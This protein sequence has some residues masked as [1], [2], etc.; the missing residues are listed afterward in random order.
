MLYSLKCTEMLIYLSLTL[1]YKGVLLTI[2]NNM[3]KVE[4]K[5]AYTLN[6]QFGL[7][8]YY[9]NKTWTRIFDS[10]RQALVFSDKFTVFTVTVWFTAHA[11]IFIVVVFHNS[12]PTLQQVHR[13][14]I[15]T[16][17]YRFVAHITH[18]V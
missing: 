9:L 2:Y 6:L 18:K 10:V 14:H 1:H 8:L 7:R 11:W 3:C 4:N 12:L 13:I 16:V 5:S 15:N 17:M